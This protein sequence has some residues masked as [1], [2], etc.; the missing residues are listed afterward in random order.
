MSAHQM[1]V[2]TNRMMV[3][4]LGLTTEE[5]ADA[6]VS[7]TRR[8]TYV[9]LDAVSPVDGEV[10]GNNWA[11]EVSHSCLKMGLKIYN[12]SKTSINPEAC[13]MIQC[14]KNRISRMKLSIG[15]HKPIAPF[16]QSCGYRVKQSYDDVL[17]KGR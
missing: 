16:C 2:A 15:Q 9:S 17:L 7:R 3:A 5:V 6:V 11:L 8:G 10:L 13:R 1:R 12:K 14:R 4:H